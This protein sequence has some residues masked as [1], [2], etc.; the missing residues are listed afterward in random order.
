MN[1]KQII[2]KKYDNTELQNAKTKKNKFKNGNIRI[3]GF[4]NPYPHSA[5]RCFEC[6]CLAGP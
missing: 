6:V 5:L 3:L 4:H 2:F 1:L